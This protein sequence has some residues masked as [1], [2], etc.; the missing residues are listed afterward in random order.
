MFRGNGSVQSAQVQGPPFA[1]TPVG[2]CVAQ[3]FY[4]AHIP[5]FSGAAPPLSKSFTVN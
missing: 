2:G 1:G 3:R 4:G 5:A